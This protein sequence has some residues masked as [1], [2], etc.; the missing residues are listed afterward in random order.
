MR[1]SPLG[2]G[3]PCARG[4]FPHGSAR[5]LGCVLRA[6]RDEGA[7]ARGWPPT[8]LRA[9]GQGAHEL[10]FAWIPCWE[11]EGECGAS[12]WRAGTRR[13]GALEPTR[14]GAGHSGRGPA[15]ARRG[16]GIWRGG[17]DNAAWVSGAGRGRDWQRWL[18]GVGRV[19]AGS[20]VAGTERAADREPGDWPRAP[21]RWKAP[22]SEAPGG[23]PG[24][25]RRGAGRGGPSEA[26]RGKA[27][28]AGRSR[29]LGGPRETPR[30]SPGDSQV[31]GMCLGLRF[32]GAEKG[33][34][35]RDASEGPGRAGARGCA[36]RRGAG[37][38][39]GRGARCARGGRC[40]RRGGRAR[41][42]ERGVCA[43]MS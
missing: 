4:L 31:S 21:A 28:S 36:S 14:S 6:G 29:G 8:S 13:R 43:E 10:G 24:A 2:T 35:V 33:K 3:A 22:R 26:G 30:I 38:G 37:R 18:A 25:P 12:R 39:G 1:R 19:R 17:G 7:G 32:K 15:E 42:R 23:E 27:E 9:R 40:E 34:A 5:A 20:G 16:A 41:S 11:A